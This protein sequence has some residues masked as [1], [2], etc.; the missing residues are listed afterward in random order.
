MVGM[1]FSTNRKL[2]IAV[3]A[4]FTL[5][6]LLIFWPI[7][8]GKVNLNGNLL[9][10][11]YPPYGQNLPY[12]DTGWDQLRIYFPFLK[13][14]ADSWRNLEIPHWNPYAFSGHPHLADFQTAV[15]YPLN[16]VGIFLGQIGFWHFARITPT[17]LA[18]F[19]TF[20]YLSNLRIAPIAALFGAITFGFSP[21]IL[22]WGE[23]VVMSPHSIVWLPLILWAIDKYREG[24]KKHYLVWISLSTASSLLG[25]Y[26]QTSI[27]MF[28]LVVV[29]L[30]FRLWQTKLQTRFVGQFQTGFGILGAVILGVGIAAVQLLPSA[31]LY[32]N[33]ARA[34]IP[35]RETL[36]SFLLPIESLI[37]Y[38]S[39]DF[40]GHPA[41]WNFFR[42]GGQYYEGILFFGVA[43]LVFA[44]F[45]IYSKFRDKFVLLLTG[46][47]LLSL[48][49]TLDLPTSRLFLSAPIPFLSTSIANR[50]L[51]IP[52]FC[53]AVV[54]AIGMDTWLKS[55]DRKILH[56]L[57]VMVVFYAAI[58]AA[59]ILIWKMNWPYFERGKLFASQTVIISLRN[60]VI[61][62]F[63]F[64]IC[65]MTIILGHFNKK[66][67]PIFAFVI[68]VISFL[69]IFYFAQKYFSFSDRRFVFPDNKILQFI[70][71]NQAQY[72]S[73]GAGDGYLENNFASQYQLFWPEGYDSL[74]NRSY[75]EFTY[76]MQGNR[77][78]SY[79][80][81]ADAG[82]GRGKISEVIDNPQRRRLMDLVGVKF[83]IAKVQDLDI[84]EKNNFK[85][86]FADN[87]LA[88]FEN[89]S[90][91]PRA[92]LASNYEGP[93]PLHQGFEGQA[94]DEVEKIRRR[95]II[96]KLLD[97]D[98]DFKNV[99]ILEKPSAISPQFGQGSVEFVSYK[100][101]EVVI[102]TKSD[103]PKLLF[104]SDNWYPGWKAIVDGDPTEILRADYTF[105]AV[106]L[107]AGE[108][109]VRFYFDSDLFK[110]G[111]FLSALGLAGS[112]LLLLRGEYFNKR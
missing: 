94:P 71:K 43:A 65:A 111:L 63:I 42:G 28:I 12:K 104:L 56:V 74:N 3:F 78:E 46:I 105:R 58:L 93:P 35:L 17:I 91:L 11:F 39:P 106:P 64:L 61:P 92:F 77:L 4:L 55:K 45:G 29:Y 52:T 82:L 16:L 72:R 100:P 27:Y 79:V 60:M 62:T 37:T 81:R 69:H 73:W 83:V 89:L 84:L 8:V 1:R 14:T 98:F 112:F 97:P 85:K 41:T 108:H 44:L 68:I 49:T 109:M 2:L 5:L 96:T 9:V 32:F 70:S 99:L 24:R 48:S 107:T 7:F 110:I 36:Y 23:E 95:M 67:R 19:F 101:Q 86:V 15:F 33:S 90:V 26:M 10:S 54:A 80:F 102:K 57:G 22:T 20:L 50:V 66:R 38:I 47:G 87:G 30:G 53:F 34:S 6:T 18:S 31:E 25:G 21:F 51:F 103:Q 76:A 40:F 59:L 75:S 13:I 88:V